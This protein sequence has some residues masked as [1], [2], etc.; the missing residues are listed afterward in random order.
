MK[1]VRL[2]PDPTF[3]GGNEN[4]HIRQTSRHARA[5]RNDDGDGAGTSGRRPRSAHRFSGAR[6]TTWRVLPQRTL[7]GPAAP[8]HC[9]RARAD[10]RREAAGTE[11]DAGAPHSRAMI[12]TLEQYKV[13]E[14]AGSGSLGDVYRAR[15]TRVGRT[16]AITVVMDQIASN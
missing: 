13:L 4:I 9:P 8:G 6:R 2:K 14:S 12:D 16:V 15:D 5:P 11:R 1:Q 3:S 7:S 10:G